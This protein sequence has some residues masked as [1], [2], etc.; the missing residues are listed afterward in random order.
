MVKNTAR[1]AIYL[2]GAVL[3]ILAGTSLLAT[4]F[5]I[6]KTSYV[7]TPFADVA[8]P[9]TSTMVPVPAFAFI[10]LYWL[11]D[12]VGETWALILYVGLGIGL[13]VG[14]VAAFLRGRATL[15]R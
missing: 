2:L 14:G 1:R 5:I 3:L 4:A 11:V 10:V 9:N 13:V 12:R 15:T 8:S 6:V 7:P